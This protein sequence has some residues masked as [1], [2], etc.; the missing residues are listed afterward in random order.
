MSGSTLNTE[1]DQ[2]L[3][4]AVGVIRNS[5]GDI[6]IAKRAEVLHQGGLWEFPGGKVEPGESV[7]QALGRELFE[8]LG[9]K[10]GKI[11]PLI[12][13]SHAY[14]D[15]NVL[16]DVWW[17]EN[18]SGE[19]YGK[20]RQPI[21]WVPVTQLKNY[22]FPEANWPIRRAVELPSL[23][24][25]LD[26]CEGESEAE[27]IRKLVAI[28]ESG[29]RLIQLRGKTIIR[30]RFQELACVIKGRCDSCSAKLLLNSSPD[31]VE[32]I[33]ADGVHLSSRRLNSLSSRPLDGGFLV[34]ASCHNLDELKHACQVG[35]D[36]VV[37]SPV[38]RTASHP[39]TVPLGWGNFEAL[40]ENCNVPVYGLGGLQ[41]SDRE[42]V[43]RLGAQGIAG[44]S[45]FQPK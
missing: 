15:R 26:V 20:E 28:L 43:Q 16:L 34:S 29:C 19:P 36:F 30:E 23:Y 11:S 17:V 5:N 32:T 41:L 24:G 18:F 7:E 12:K 45:L 13:T 10:I 4:V 2:R 39:E 44:I 25:I 31:L 6:L 35:V 27:S 37:L 3:H 33:G 9:I 40:V 38:L 22:P 42:K 8:E 1:P 14:P 21:R